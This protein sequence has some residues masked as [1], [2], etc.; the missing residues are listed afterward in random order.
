MNLKRCIILLC[1]PLFLLWVAG[2]S[3]AQ[4][5]DVEDYA[6]VSYDYS[7]NGGNDGFNESLEKQQAEPGVVEVASA[8]SDGPGDNFARAEI[9]EKDVDYAKGALAHSEFSSGLYPDAVSGGSGAA[10]SCVEIYMSKTFDIVFPGEASVQFSL[11]GLLEARGDAIASYDFGV[12]DE[13][14]H[15]FKDTDSVAGG[16]QAVDLL[17][18]FSYAFSADDTDRSLTLTFLLLINAGSSDSE[19]WAKADFLDTMQIDSIFGAIQASEGDDVP[20]SG[21][22]IQNTPVPAAV[23]LL[24]S[25]LVGMIGCRNRI[26]Q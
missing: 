6:G 16:E 17:E 15:Y 7:F 18:A 3:S 25:G 14:G 19:G 5:M 1:G 13:F 9:A 12:W 2:A 23:W 21:P 8:F 26:R 24:L 20:V 22:P 10:S 11:D 4:L